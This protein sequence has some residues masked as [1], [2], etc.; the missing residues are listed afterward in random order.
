MQFQQGEVPFFLF[1]LKWPFNGLGCALEIPA[2]ANPCMTNARCSWLRAREASYPSWRCRHEVPI[3]PQCW[4]CGDRLLVPCASAAI[5]RCQKP[6]RSAHANGP[7]EG[8]GGQ[9][10]TENRRTCPGRR[11]Q[12]HGRSCRVVVGFF[13]TNF[14]TSAE[15]VMRMVTYHQGTSGQSCGGPGADQLIL[16]PGPRLPERG[17]T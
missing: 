14:P 9:P 5:K 2:A 16:A 6:V 3:D 1:N 13:R 7:M 11:V 15:E 4:G 8:D 12:R 17:P 10:K